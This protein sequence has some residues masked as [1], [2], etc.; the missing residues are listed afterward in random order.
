MEL[1][2][3]TEMLLQPVRCERCY[4]R[5]YAWRTIPALEQ[6]PMVRKPAQSQS[7]SSP[8]SGHRVA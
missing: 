4:H 5:T 2:R 8:E 7:Q 3:F 1:S 6:A